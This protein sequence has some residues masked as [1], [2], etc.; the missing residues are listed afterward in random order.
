MI[1]VL[2]TFIPTIPLTEEQLQGFQ[3]QAVWVPVP[4][5]KDGTF[6]AYVETT[7]D[8]ES[9]KA[10]LETLGTTHIIGVWNTDGTQFGFERQVTQ[11]EDGSTT[12]TIV[13]VENPLTYPL[14]T[15]AYIDALLDEVVCDENGV[16]V[17]RTRPTTMK[18]V[19][20]FAGMADRML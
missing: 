18:A 17:S 12:E 5:C 13:Q 6:Q 19:N 8:I 3:S 1:N 15:Q 9:I 7:Q 10:T 16:E 2:F 11:N 14:D 20:K 4:E